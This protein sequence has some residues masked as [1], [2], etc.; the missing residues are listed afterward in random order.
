MGIVAGF[1]QTL[2]EILGAVR[3]IDDPGS[4]TVNGLE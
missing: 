3:A 4:D 2:D 1:Q